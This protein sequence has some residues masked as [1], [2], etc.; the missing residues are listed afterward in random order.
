MHPKNLHQRPYQFKELITANSE[1]EQFVFVNEFNTQTIDFNNPSAVYQLNRA[2][3]KSDYGLSEYTIPEGYLCPPIPSRADY[4][5]HI[6]TILQEEKL[7]GAIKGL[8][9]GVGANCIY[10]ILASKIYHWKMVGSDI[11]KMAVSA[12]IA[13]VNCNPELSHKIEIRQQLQNANI[14]EGIIQPKE[15]FHF[16]MCNPP[17]YNSKENAERETQNKLKGLSYAIDTKRNFGG[18]PNELW[19]NGGES[20][21][22]KRMIKQ[23]FA[24]KK[25]VGIFTSLVSKSESLPKI[26]KQLIKLGARYKVVH[27]TQGNKKSRI[28]SWKFL[29]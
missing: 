27:I 7:H 12:A 4:V 3:L 23:S 10:P 9:I 29:D 25:Q 24:F 18:M 20:L 19:C 2:I 6:H 26:K 11:N 28:I 13:N 17:F 21:F 16:T 22:L 15:Y 1:L 5:H 8:D 14:F